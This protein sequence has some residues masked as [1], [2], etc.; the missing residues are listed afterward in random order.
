M[1]NVSKLTCKSSIKPL[2]KDKFEKPSNTNGSLNIERG[3]VSV[4]KKLVKGTGP[5]KNH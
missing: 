1:T 5:R 2:L 3:F 4:Q